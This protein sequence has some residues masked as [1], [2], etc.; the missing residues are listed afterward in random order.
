MWFAIGD[1]IHFV[2]P[3]HLPALAFILSSLPIDWCSVADAYFVYS[4]HGEL[5]AEIQH[6]AKILLRTCPLNGDIHL[7]TSTYLPRE[8]SSSLSTR[9]SRWNPR[10]RLTIESPGFWVTVWPS[11]TCSSYGALIWTQNTIS[12]YK[13]SKFASRGSSSDPMTSRPNSESDVTKSVEGAMDHFLVIILEN[14]SQL[15]ETRL[16][17]VLSLRRGRSV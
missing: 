14:I 7:A 4:Q 6:D 5:K 2:S 3:G 11:R 13:F 16:M 9:A 10:N 8:I 1:Q 17:S 15:Y 12:N